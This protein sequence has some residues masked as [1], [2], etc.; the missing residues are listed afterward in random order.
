[1]FKLLLVW[2]SNTV[3]IFHVAPCRNELSTFELDSHYSFQEIISPYA[4]I[5]HQK[6]TSCLVYMHLSQTLSFLPPYYQLPAFVGAKTWEVEKKVK[7]DIQG[8]KIPP[9]SPSDTL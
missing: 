7:E 6:T 4:I 3:Q 5:L 9:G 1:M 8:V 2:P